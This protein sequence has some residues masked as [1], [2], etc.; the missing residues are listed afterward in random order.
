MGVV[1]IRIKVNGKE[2]ETDEATAMLFV[3][4]GVADFVDEILTATAEP[5][6]NAMKRRPRKRVRSGR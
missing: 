1:V 5:P 6:C 2:I 4:L 3:E